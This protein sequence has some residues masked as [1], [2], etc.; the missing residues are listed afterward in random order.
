MKHNK[1]KNSILK[2]VTL[3][4]I[5]N[6]IINFLPPLIKYT[7]AG[8]CDK[9]Y[10]TSTKGTVS[11]K[12]GRSLGEYRITHYSPPDNTPPGSRTIAGGSGEATAHRT[13]AIN[14]DGDPNGLQMGDAVVI[15]D[16]VYVV[17]DLG[18][19]PRSRKFYRYIC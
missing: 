16:E 6:I 18:N 15:G 11:G 4:I 7:K 2:I 17:E 19:G 3:S 10:A 8:L 5:I 9:D 13:C 14:I 1:I 12:K